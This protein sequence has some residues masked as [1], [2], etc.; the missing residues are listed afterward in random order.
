MVTRFY[1][2]VWNAGDVEV[3]DAEIFAGAVPPDGEG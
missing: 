3:A 2:E 1:D